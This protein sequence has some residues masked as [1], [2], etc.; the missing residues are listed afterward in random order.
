MGV[1]VVQVTTLARVNSVGGLTTGVNDA[2]I[3]ELITAVSQYAQNHMG[4]YLQQ[5]AR[6]E[7]VRVIPTTRFVTLRGMPI[8]VVTS[9]KYSARRYFTET[10]PLDA[11]VD[12]DVHGP[13]GQVELR[14]PTRNDPGY[15]QVDY[16]GGMATTT[17]AFVAEYPEIAEAAA[18]EVVNHLNRS[19]NPDGNVEAMGANVAYRD[20]IKP[21][22]S[23]LEVLDSRRRIRL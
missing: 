1:P 12:Y 5:T 17:D 7:I 6:S 18:K 20:E 14:I 9:V 13:L 21:L 22:A 4:R 3:A 8:T 10:D 16:T 15:V 19:K 23:F 11:T 2:R